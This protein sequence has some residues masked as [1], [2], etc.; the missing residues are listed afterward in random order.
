MLPGDDPRPST[1][2][3]E[4]PPSGSNVRRAAE[5]LEQASKAMTLAAELEVDLPGQLFSPAD[6][7]RYTVWWK[8][9]ER[10]WAKHK[11]AMESIF[12][13]LEDDGEALKAARRGDLDELGRR[14]RAFADLCNQEIA[15]LLDRLQKGLDLLEGHPDTPEREKWLQALTGMRGKVRRLLPEAWAMAAPAA[16]LYRL[17]DEEHRAEAEARWGPLT[18][19][20]PHDFSPMWRTHFPQAKLADVDRRLKEIDHGD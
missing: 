19:T 1:V 17:L 16:H 7:R 4:S 8:T 2:A 20:D 3:L 15:P 10:G 13:E 11:A 5:L 12:G 9:R 6:A 14:V 18:G